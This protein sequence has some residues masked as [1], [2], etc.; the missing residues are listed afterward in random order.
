MKIY[1]QIIFVISVFVVISTKG[2]SANEQYIRRWYFEDWYEN[3]SSPYNTPKSLTLTDGRIDEMLSGSL[4]TNNFH[5]SEQ[6]GVV[7]LG[8]REKS[9]NYIPPGTISSFSVDLQIKYFT[10]GTNGLEQHSTTR[11]AEV[12]FNMVEGELVVNKAQ[13]KIN[14]PGAV[15]IQVKVLGKFLHSL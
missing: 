8:I 1:L 10:Y 3:T 11:T 13:Y 15:M 2:Y 7:R 9:F 5:N 4:W 14:L 6:V 12:D